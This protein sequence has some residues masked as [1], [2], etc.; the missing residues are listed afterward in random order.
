MTKNYPSKLLELLQYGLID[1]AQELLSQGTD[2]NAGILGFRPIYAAIHSDDPNVLQ[3]VVDNGADVNIDEGTP[4]LE[5]LD[6]CIDGMIQ[7]E[8]IEPY[9]EA[10]RMLQILLDNGADP[11]LKN[12]EGHRPIDVLTEYAASKERTLSRLINLFES[13]IPNLRDLLS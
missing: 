8:R 12:V 5:I 9:P 4:L 7:A 2:I 13:Y 11:F 6:Y 1:E 10:L 3:F